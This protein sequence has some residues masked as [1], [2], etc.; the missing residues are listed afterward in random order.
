MIEYL[1]DTVKQL[2]QL[3]ELDVGEFTRIKSRGMNFHVRVFDAKDGGRLFLMDMLAF[4]GLMKMETVVFTP[5]HID[6]PI[7]S[8][9]KVRAFGRSTLVLELYDTTISHPNFHMLDKIKRK[10]ASIPSYDP[11]NY[12]YY[13]FRLPESDYKRGYRIKESINSMLEEYSQNYFQRLQFCEP[14]EPTK[15]K[16]K[17]AEFTQS[18]FQNGGL[19][20]NHF[21]KMIGDEKTEEF[22]MKYM[23]CSK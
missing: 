14:I 12:P 9:D 18:L 7:L 5:I 20:V 10:Y 1:Y 8:L 15:K 23:F 19:A 13:S 4:C 6:A 17:N 2:F 22:L 3:T 16:N 11:G 21:K